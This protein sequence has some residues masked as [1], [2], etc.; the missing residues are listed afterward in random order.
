MN[1]RIPA[2]A[3]ALLAGGLLPLLTGALKANYRCILNSG[4]F[5]SYNC[6]SDSSHCYSLSD[7][8]QGY[9]CPY[10]TCV[11]YTG[12]SCNTYPN[13]VCFQEV[14]YDES[15]CTDPCDFAVNTVDEGCLQP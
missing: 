13:Q 9:A 10:G 2:I 6:S 11:T 14:Y 15:D 4:C 7:S 1:R 12:Q 5:S 3:T 8:K